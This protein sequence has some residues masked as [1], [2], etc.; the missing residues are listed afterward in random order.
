MKWVGYNES[1]NPALLEKFAAR[2]FLARDVP[3]ASGPTAGG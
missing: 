1:Q 3:K 2:F